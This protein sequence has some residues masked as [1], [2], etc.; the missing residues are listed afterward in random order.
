M[1]THQ[2]LA[3]RRHH[4][5]PLQSGI[6]LN[7]VSLRCPGT[8]TPAIE[9]LSVDLPAHA[10]IAVVGE[11]GAGKSSLVRLLTRLDDPT[12]GTI[13]WDEHHDAD[14]N[15]ATLQARI[16]ASFH[17][18]SVFD[19]T[20]AENITWGTSHRP[21]TPNVCRKPWPAHASLASCLA[22]P[23]ALRPPSAT[24]SPQPGSTAT[25]TLSG[26]QTQRLS[27]GRALYRRQP[28]PLILDEPGSGLDP[29][30][31]QELMTDLLSHPPAVLT[32]LVTH[33][34]RPLPRADLILVMHHGALVECGTHR[35]L[36]ARAGRYQAMWRDQLGKD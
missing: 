27:I 34:L 9:D 14:L 33:R 4:R 31:E 1:N 17:D 29:L 36:L 32:V 35:Q 11:N 10:V 28:D 5:A 24:S 20:V 23:P 18:F 30:A 2:G 13:S 15:L 12:G 22:F 8:A 25:T 19:T 26:G 3:S 16:S 6:Y 7:K 21:M